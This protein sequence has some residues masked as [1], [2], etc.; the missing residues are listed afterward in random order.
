MTYVFVTTEENAAAGVAVHSYGGIIMPDDAADVQIAMM[1]GD[2][3]YTGT[4]SATAAVGDTV[5]M[6]AEN[7]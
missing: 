5:E 3:P 4:I 7:P 1:I 6:S 2:K